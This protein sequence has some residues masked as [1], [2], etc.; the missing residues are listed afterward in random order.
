MPKSGETR[1]G[2]RFKV[3]FGGKGAN[4]AVM[5]GRLGAVVNFIGK[6]GTDSFGE[7]TITN[8][9]KNGIRWKG[10]F[11]DKAMS[12]VASI[13][14]DSTGDKSI[15]IEAG[16][17]N[18]LTEDEVRRHSEAIT[19][20]KVLLVQNE[21]PIAA[22]RAAL[23]IGRKAGV[24]TVFNPAPVP[25]QASDMKA[26]LPFVDI[27]NPNEIELQ[28]L[29]GARET[30]TDEKVV[31]AA[32]SL[33]SAHDGL[34]VVLVTLEERGTI[35][36]TRDNVVVKSGV[37]VK[38][39]DTVGVGGCF[40]GSFAYFY[41]LDGDLEAAVEKAAIVRSLSAKGSGGQTS[42]PDRESA[43]KFVEETQKQRAR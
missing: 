42:Y 35:I 9:K 11:T 7:N 43:L 13:T 29:T 32:R 10:F 4:Q 23:E 16:A 25:K 15:V 18:L 17:N 33:L 3:G 12:G 31:E 38:Q 5:A 28:M 40:L 24:A 21:I 22:T 2:D 34:K 6:L 26:V 39:V 41:A 14:V 27:L 36:V 1:R 30:S 8:F 19:S 20:S 37:K